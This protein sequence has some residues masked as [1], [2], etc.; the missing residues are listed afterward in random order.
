MK[1]AVKRCK[2][3]KNKKFQHDLAVGQLQEIFK[4]LRKRFGEEIYED[5]AGIRDEKIR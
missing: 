5:I 1:N 2:R 3:T 4:M